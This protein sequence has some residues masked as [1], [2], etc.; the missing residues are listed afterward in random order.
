MAI[1]NGIA[2]DYLN[3][4]QRLRKYLTGSFSVENELPKVGNTGDGYLNYLLCGPSAVA[5][6]WTVTC[7]TGG[8]NGVAIFSVTGSVSGPQTAVTAGTPQFGA[9]LEIGVRAGAS[10]YIIG[11]EYT[12]DV[13]ANSI[14][15]G[16]QWTELKYSPGVE[17]TP[18]ANNSMNVDPGGS[19]PLGEG[20][21]ANELYLKG[22][23]LAGADAIH[24]N[25]FTNYD[26]PGDYY[27]LGFKG[28]TGFETLD[29]FDNQPGASSLNGMM[30]WQFQIPYW[31]VADGRRFIITYK[32]STYYMS[33]YFGFIL[34][35]AT[36]TEY[37]YPLYIGGSYTNANL[38]WSNES[39]NHRSFFD[40]Y[41][42]YMYTIEGTW[43]TIQ[44]K[45]DS[46]G[47]EVAPTTSNI[48]PYGGNTVSNVRQS[49]GDVYP[50]LP[51]VMHSSS[52]GGNVLGEL[53][54]C[55][56]CPGFANA[57]ENTLV[58]DAVDYI[59]F[60]DVY[61]AG[62]IDYYALKQE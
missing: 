45:Y 32:I 13:V 44:N 29:N 27:N 37:P 53:S 20:I 52:N 1:H 9:I 47:T 3:L 16:Q 2:S 48:W 42:A 56:W 25:M 38:K 24:V 34:P 21:Y 59:I 62:N 61:R 40:P 5:E 43:L 18:G 58:V 10:D 36:P 6:T 11:D 26:E 51:M 39:H 19:V 50:M 35:Y 33:G 55:F 7:T 14:P 57:S 46:S 49:P 12:F 15:V 54:G 31:I 22:P 30:A 28:A 4:F 8:G 41:A 23:G 17:I 60:Q